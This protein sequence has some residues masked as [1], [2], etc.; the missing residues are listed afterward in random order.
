MTKAVETTVKRG[1]GAPRKNKEAPNCVTAQLTPEERALVETA[2][3]KDGRS[4]SNFLKMAM[5]E[6][7]FKILGKE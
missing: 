4:L 5:V 6:R 2:A 3:E 1:R 7:A